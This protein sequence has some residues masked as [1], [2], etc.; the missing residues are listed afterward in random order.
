MHVIYSIERGLMLT[1]K[2][3]SDAISSLNKLSDY[4][5]SVYCIWPILLFFISNAFQ[6]ELKGFLK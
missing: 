2:V 5:I 6:V 4:L 1:Y 3:Y